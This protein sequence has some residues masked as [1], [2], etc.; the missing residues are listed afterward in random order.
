MPHRLEASAYL[1][2]SPPRFEGLIIVRQVMANV[3]D[4]ANFITARRSF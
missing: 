1:H 4:L 3:A 2:L